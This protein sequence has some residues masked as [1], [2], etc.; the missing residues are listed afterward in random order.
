MPSAAVWVA[1]PV[2]S[3]VRL[4]GSVATKLPDPGMQSRL[5]RVTLVVVQGCPTWW[6]SLQTLPRHC[7]Q[8]DGRPRVRK[9]REARLMLTDDSPVRTLRVPLPSVAKELTTQVEGKP[10]TGTGGPKKH[11]GSKAQ[12]PRNPAQS[13]SLEHETDGL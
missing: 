2:E 6:P 4:T 12:A 1:V 7:G 13:A 3:G 8:A 10:F 5:V 11:V 9:T